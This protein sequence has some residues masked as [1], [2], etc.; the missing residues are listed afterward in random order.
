[1]S[2][3]TIED[4]RQRFGAVQIALAPDLD[5]CEIKVGF[6][7]LAPGDKAAELIERADAELLTSSGR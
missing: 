4:A 2:G 7:A 5:Q 6:A 1:M 3:A